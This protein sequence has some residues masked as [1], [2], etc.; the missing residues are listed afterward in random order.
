MPPLIELEKVEKSY[1]MPG[2]DVRA[3]KRIDLEIDVGEFVSVV[4]SSGSG[5]ST[6][7]YLLGLLSD[8]T[9]GRYDLAGKNV[10]SLDDEER[11]A[12]RAREIGFIFQSFH[13]VP[14]QNV[15]R[16]VLL[17]ARYHPAAKNG[18]D[19]PGTLEQRARS[20]IERVGLGHRIEHRPTEL[21]NGEMQRVAIC[22]ALLN[23]PK[24]VL[25]DE[26]TGNLDEQNGNE[27]FRLLDALRD[28]GRTVVMVTHDLGL[29]ARTPRTIRLKDGEVVDA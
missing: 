6:L 8:P 16:N 23:E 4:G 18:A 14:Q 9:S 24:L 17:A 15:L 20:L 7:L 11:S 13:L 10:G 26:P 27:I 22:R 5:K 12:V 19:G 29:A 28:E 2:G 3:L 21:S 25:A 1:P